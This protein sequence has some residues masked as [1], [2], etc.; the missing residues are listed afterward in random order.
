MPS[1]EITIPGRGTFQI[2]SP[3]ELSDAQAYQAAM[4]QSQ[5][6][7][8]EEV[9][10][11][12][13]GIT[14][15]LRD[16]I[17]AMA[18]TL[19]RILSYATSLGGNVENEVSKF[20]RD[21]AAQ[22]DALNLA[23]E[24]KY[25]EQ[26]K[27][28]GRE[29]IDF[30]RIAG[31]IV[32]PANLAVAARA[33]SA[34]AGVGNVVSQL[35]MLTTVGQKIVQGA[36]TPVGQAIIGG[37]AAGALEPVFDAETKDFA[38][39]KAK[40][41]G[42]GGVLGG[43]TQKA[44]S[45]LGRV[46]SPQTAPEVRALYEQGVELT[47]GQILGGGA[48]KIEEGLKSIPIA[49]DI[50]AS[51]ERRS[52]ESFNRATIN[53]ALKPIGAKV[54]KNLMGRDLIQFADDEIGKSYNKYLTKI[55]LNADNELLKDLASITTRAFQELPQQRVDQLNSIIGNTILDRMKGQIKGTAWKSI[56]S[57]L[58]RLASNYLN[59]QSGDERLLGDAIKETQLSVRKLLERANP[60]F[61]EEIGKTNRAFADFLRV[62]KAASSIGAQ[63]GV[64]SPA[65]LLSATRSLDESLRKGKFAK[66]EA[67][68][69]GT[70][71]AA[72]KVMGANLPDSGTAYRGLTGAGVVGGALLDPTT[73]LAPLGVSAAY[74]KPAQDL[75]RL[76]MLER[77]DLV[78]QAGSRLSAASPRISTVLMPGLLGEK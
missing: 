40:Q 52:I 57:D 72:K 33:P 43:V 34:V 12:S 9:K 63:E 32:N 61:A 66:G 31:N 7:M 14:R 69:Q 10:G 16:P 23:V 47:P 74:S 53:E 77:P 26:R 70:A 68:M 37:A 25:Q 44:I 38:T 42:I 48:K 3:K 36:A 49:G 21:Q 51:A 62:Q 27:K 24:Q 35:P 71:E 67:R 46:A 1:Y 19:P 8:K 30:Q 17:D 50:V 4:S 41:A 11:V 65:Q 64:F 55:D 29:G 15:G 60:K 22:V 76:L 20:F 5:Q 56:D 59:S 73:L 6:E 18:Q 13:G 2:E 28:E 54:P 78:R 39:E 75:I 45:G 58:G